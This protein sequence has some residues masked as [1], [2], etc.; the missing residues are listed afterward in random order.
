MVALCALAAVAPACAQNA[1]ARPKPSGAQTR[2]KQQPAPVPVRNMTVKVP[3]T[4]ASIELVHVPA[5]SVVVADPR[6][7]GVRTT[8]PVKAFWIA[9]TELT[10]EAYDPFVYGLAPSGQA[11]DSRGVDAMARPSKPYIP[12]DLGWGHNGFPV[13]NVTHHAATQYCAWLSA[14]TGRKFRLPTEAEWQWAAQG[15]S[16]GPAPK[17]AALDAAAWHRG[18]SNGQT[19]AVA[20]KKPNALGLA[21]MLGNTGEWAND[22][23]GKPVLCGGSWADAREAVHPGAREYQSSDWN[24]TD[25]QMPKS[26]WWLSDGSFVGFRVVCE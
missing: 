7:K 6:K 26:K 3:G 25:P 12:P 11:A 17:G 22:L 2:A 15:A 8:V 21:D 10:W 18:N 23:A 1:K 20:T 9:R 19:H 14:L 16:A 13:I 4:T 5:G 24:A